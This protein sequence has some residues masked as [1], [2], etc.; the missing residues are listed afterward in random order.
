MLS[1]VR[2]AAPILS[3]DV[4]RA[5]VVDDE[6]LARLRLCTLLGDHHDFAVVAECADGREAL[7]AVRRTHPDVIFL[8]IQM[9]ETTGLEVARAL[10]GADAP[11]I[12][13]VTA[14][15]AHALRAFE[16]HAVDYLLK[17]FD[18]ER[19]AQTLDRIRTRRAGSVAQ[20]AHARLLSLLRDLSRGSAVAGVPAVR[21]TLLHV[22][23]VT[24]DLRA[25]AVRRG[26]APVT[27]RPKEFELLVALMRRAGDV[28]GRRELLHDVWGYSDSVASRT[29]D[30]HI[31]ELR[32]KLGH[33][34]GQPGH[35]AT[36]ARTGYRLEV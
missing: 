4:I 33:A 24:V 19:F 14:Y 3:T 5:I 35:I 17:P 23:D 2:N 28:I 16:L 31:A 30:T 13:F 15:D 7:G 32:R 8:D 1:N 36:V 25:R 34:D 11:A 29:V 9:A 21:P 10:D 6:P 12:V 18:E 26:D 22:G 27:L 20:Q